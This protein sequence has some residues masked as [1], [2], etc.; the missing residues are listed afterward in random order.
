MAYDED[1]VD[2]V[3]E[4]LSGEPDVTERRMFGGLA[5][6]VGGK[7]ALTVSREGGLL[8]R[9]DPAK[10]DALAETTAARP[11]VMRGREMRGWL[12]VGSDALRTKRELS[13]WVGLAKTYSA[14]LP[15]QKSTSTRRKRS[16]SSG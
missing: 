14:S 6:M 5:F 12:R 7:M 9:V 1:L 11:A 4:Q 15:A 16:A 2:R 10:A 8:L 3:R 13:K